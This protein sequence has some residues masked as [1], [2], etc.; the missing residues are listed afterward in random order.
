[1]SK[2]CL[3]SW[4]D[5]GLTTCDECHWRDSN[6]CTKMFVPSEAKLEEYLLLKPT[7]ATYFRRQAC[8]DAEIKSLT[9]PKRDS[10]GGHTVPRMEQP[11][12]PDCGCCVRVT[13]L[14]PDRVMV[15]KC[16]VCGATTI[17]PHTHSWSPD[18]TLCARCYVTG[19]R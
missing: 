3:H 15:C 1:M 19:A 13:D 11:T 18:G 12:R 10:S 16:E 14:Q 7:G 5:A 9:P 8:L 4:I 17:A 6:C 2:R